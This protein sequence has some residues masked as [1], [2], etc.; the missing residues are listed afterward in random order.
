MSKWAIV[1]IFATIIIATVWVIWLEPM[2]PP[3]SGTIHNKMTHPKYYP[4]GPT[5]YCVGII[6][7]DRKTICSWY[8]PEWVYVRYHVGDS[9]GFPAGF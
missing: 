8:V 7:A 4:D 1:I 5:A 2:I 9:I 3:M 6:S